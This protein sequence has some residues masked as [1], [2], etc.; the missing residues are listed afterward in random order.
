MLIPDC[1]LLLGS[2]EVEY[3]HFYRIFIFVRIQITFRPNAVDREYTILSVT[4]FPYRAPRHRPHGWRACQ[5]LGLTFAVRRNKLKK[6]TYFPENVVCM[7]SFIWS[8]S[9]FIL[10]ND[11]VLLLVSIITEGLMNHSAW[12]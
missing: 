2:N 5:A 6:L 7:F 11:P 8:W 1:Y 4:T 3:I 12:G 10:R 9:V